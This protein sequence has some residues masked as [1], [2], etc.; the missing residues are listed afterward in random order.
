MSKNYGLKIPVR[1]C[2]CARMYARVYDSGQIV[3][4]IHDQH[5][6]GAQDRKREEHGKA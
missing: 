4:R 1:V 2:M 3:I 6:S 5:T